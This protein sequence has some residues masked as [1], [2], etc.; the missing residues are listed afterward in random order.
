MSKKIN[1]P[2]WIK[3]LNEVL[4]E[5]EKQ[6]ELRDFIKSVPTRDYNH[7][8][9]LLGNG[10]NGKSVVMEVIKSLFS[11]DISEYELSDL[12]GIRSEFCLADI[13]RKKVNFCH[14]LDGINEAE[15]KRMIS[16]EKMLCR[17]PY[18]K[19]HLS[20]S[21]PL[22]ICEANTIPSKLSIG[23]LKRL[24]I[25]DFDVEIKIQDHSLSEK[26]IQE[27]DYIW[28]WVMRGKRKKIKKIKKI[29]VT[30][31]ARKFIHEYGLLA[32]IIV[33]YTINILWYMYNQNLAIKYKEGAY[34]SIERMLWFQL[35]KR[36]IDRLI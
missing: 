23:V 35:V 18:G 33:D 4:P 20:I 15:F 29:G 2:E 24:S 36:E 6:E 31:N 5:K 1:C 17:H 21:L 12:M 14:G 8:L 22:F 10:S 34:S 26:L 7:M 32:P 13:D 19:P 9:V 25:I 30:D 27:K 3:F 28:E 11:S 16:G